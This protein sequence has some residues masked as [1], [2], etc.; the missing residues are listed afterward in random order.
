MSLKSAADRVMP[1]QRPIQACIYGCWVDGSVVE[2]VGVAAPPRVLVAA[3][4]RVVAAPP[5][6]VAA[7]PRVV[8]TPPGVVATPPGVVAAPPGVVA[9]PAG[10]VAA[11]AGVVAAPPGVVAGVV[12]VARRVL[13]LEH[14]KAPYLFGGSGFF[15]AF[16]IGKYCSQSGFEKIEPALQ[17]LAKTP[18]PR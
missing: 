2:G 14:W 18:L 7:P 3:P 17:T 6:V 12:V 1:G 16:V 4:A 9:A 11:P 15:G 10:V 8:A 13:A 5:G